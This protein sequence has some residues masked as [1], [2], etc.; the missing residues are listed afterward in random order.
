MRLWQHL[1]PSIALFIPQIATQLYLILNKQILRFVV[2]V[3]AS[4]FYDDSDKIVKMLLAIVTATGTV[5][6]P[7]VANSFAKGDRK[8][9]RHFFVPN[10]D[11][12]SCLAM[13]TDVWHCINALQFAPWF[14]S[15][16]LRLLGH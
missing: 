16:K 10:V 8:S 4:G 2:D 12:V 7:H 3:Q 13:A 1:G 11:F 9:V 14:F 5:M 15:N 6:L